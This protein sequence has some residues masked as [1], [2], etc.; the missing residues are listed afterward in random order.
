MVRINELI[1]REINDILRTKFRSEAVA[2]T[3][4]E[5]KTAPDLRNASVFYSVLGN[6]VEK[7]NSRKFF[8]KVAKEIRFQLGKRIVLKYIPF[9]KYY[10][11]NSLEKGSELVELM[12]EIESA[13][14][15]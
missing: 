8:R 2:Y 3:V 12:D 10:I 9:L 7:E 11:D 5:I 4:I 1:R 15:E 6:E 14:N 13:E